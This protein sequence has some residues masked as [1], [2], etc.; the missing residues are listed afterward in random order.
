MVPAKTSTENL[1]PQERQ[2]VEMNQESFE[3][4]TDAML[5]RPELP[6]TRESCCMECLLMRPCRTAEGLD[7]LGLKE[8]LVDA[9]RPMQKALLAAAARIKPDIDPEEVQ[10]DPAPDDIGRYCGR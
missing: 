1:P 6:T 4:S 2:G 7:G 8:R 9:W 10:V 3:A 5:W